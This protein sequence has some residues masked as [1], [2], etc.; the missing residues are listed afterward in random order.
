M[1]NKQVLYL[2]AIWL[3]TCPVLVFIYIT[4]LICLRLLKLSII[5]ILRLISLCASESKWKSGILKPL[6]IFIS[7]FHNA[8]DK[9]PTMQHCVS[10]ICIHMHM[11]TMDLEAHSYE[12]HMKPYIH[13]FAWNLFELHKKLLWISYKIHEKFIWN[14]YG[15]QIKFLW[16]SYDMKSNLFIWIY[17]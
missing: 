14:S 12:V 17:T 6:N 2:Q 4:V 16:I 3:S 9:Y 11:S 1:S 5:I 13:N 10:E 15:V 8:L 7:K